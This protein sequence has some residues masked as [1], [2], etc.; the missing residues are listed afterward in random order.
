MV[1]KS[2]FGRAVTHTF[3]YFPGHFVDHTAF[4][5]KEMWNSLWA[6]TWRK[7][8]W[9]MRILRQIYGIDY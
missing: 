2:D 9:K 1:T 3:F 6:F 7:G 5:G 8:S 4:D